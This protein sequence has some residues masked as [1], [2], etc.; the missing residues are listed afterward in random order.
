MMLIAMAIGERINLIKIEREKAQLQSIENQNL[1]IEN[2]KKID[3]MK[4]EFL[5]NT[6]HELRTP[7]NGIIGISESLVDGIAGRLSDRANENL[8]III[9]SAKRLANLVNDILDFSKLKNKDL[10]LNLKSV[11]IKSIVDIV[12]T[13]MNT[14]KRKELEFKNLIDLESPFVMADE[15]RLHQIMNNLIGNAV[16][17]T[18]KGYVSVNVIKNNDLMSIIV[19][20]TGI[21]IPEDKLSDIFKP[22][23]QVD[24]STSRNYGGTGIGLTIQNILLSYMVEI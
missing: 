16:K 11:D 18:E 13:I 23:E 12:F 19:E 15:D 10:N 8:D 20:D 22:F 6:S 2:L 3:K 17:F 14:S 7:L 1:S 24:S 9:S 5:A 4:D 21:G